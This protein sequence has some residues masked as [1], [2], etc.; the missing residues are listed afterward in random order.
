MGDDQGEAQR[1]VATY[2]NT[3]NRLPHMHAFSADEVEHVHR[4]ALRILQE[5]GVRVL[6]P[7]AREIFARAGARLDD[8]MVYLDAAMVEAVVAHAPKAFTL[9]GRA[10]HR[11][12]T[13]DAKTVHFGAGAGC[14]NIT[15]LERGRRPGSL[16]AF[17]E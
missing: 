8:E 16:E 12:L 3:Q 10:P 11:D 2:R 14:P 9:H 6:L 4:T 5:L 17:R 15:D 13:V 1:G 7:E